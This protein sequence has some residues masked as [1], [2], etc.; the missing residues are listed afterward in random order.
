MLAV[1]GA[2]CLVALALVARSALSGDDNGSD[3]NG[4][5]GGRGDR[6]VVACVSDLAEVCRAL[7]DRGAIAADPPTLDLDEAAAPD[8]KIDAWITWDP[9]PGIANIDGPETWGEP[10][11]LGGG[12]LTILSNRGDLATLRSGCGAALT[13]ACVADTPKSGLAVGVGDGQSAESLARFYPV[14][15][16]LVP[17]GEDFTSL[18]STQL[19]AVVD[20]PANGQDR[21]KAQ[22]KTLLTAPGSLNVVVGPRPGLEAALRTPRGQAMVTS[23]PTPTGDSMTAVIV[24]RVDTDGSRSDGSESKG[25]KASAVLGVDEASQALRA[26]GV[27]PGTGSLAPP[28]R[29]GELYAVRK[30]V[31]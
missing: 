21:L 1:V 13:W 16:S 28:D 23:A 10:Q 15:A 17:A 9:A 31:G 2:V 5:G 18:T 14:A 30:K 4:G 7:A 11:V 22:V 3:G 26:A 12:A 8:E 20:S 25:L 19:R 29:A 6:P 24:S 27:E